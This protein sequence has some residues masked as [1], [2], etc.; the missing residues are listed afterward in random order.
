LLQNPSVNAVFVPIDA[1]LSLGLGQ[2]V[3]SSARAAS[4]HVIGA[5]GGASNL[6]LIRGNGGEDAT[7]AYSPLHYGYAAID[8][9]T[10]A[11]T[12]QPQVSEGITLQVVDPNH[13]MPG[14]GGYIDSPDVAG[15]YKQIWGLG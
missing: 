14:S 9:A 12:K 6:A 13:N 10:R 4:L 3:K 1:W 8:V 2:A 15:H 5:L 11:L 7:V